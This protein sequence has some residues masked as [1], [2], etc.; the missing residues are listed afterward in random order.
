VIKSVK[1]PAELKKKVFSKAQLKLANFSKGVEAEQIAANYLLGQG[2]IILERNL[3]LG[4]LEIDL[5]AL[6]QKFDE[7]VFV[8]V[9]YLLSDSLGDPSQA[10]NQVKIKKVLAVARIYLK[11]RQFQKAHR[12]DI[13]SVVGNLQKPR[14]EH[15]EN[16]TWL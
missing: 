12:F 14:V 2:Y 5:I 1:P 9:K 13:I 10:V 16:I 4:N 7:V 3:R 6:D 15:F 8:E 11:K